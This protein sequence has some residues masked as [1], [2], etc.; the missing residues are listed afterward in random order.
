LSEAASTIGIAEITAIIALVGAGLGAG[1]YAL[2]FIGVYWSVYKRITH[3]DAS[4]ALYATSLIPKTLVA[5]QGIRIFIGW[6]LLSVCLI[7]LIWW[8]QVLSGIYLHSPDWVVRV[9]GAVTYLAVIWAIFKSGIGGAL[10]TSSGRHPLFTGFA[11][12]AIYLVAGLLA[13]P[14]IISGLGWEYG[15]IIPHIV[16][17]WDLIKGLA[18]LAGMSFAAGVVEA[19]QIDPPL[20]TVKIKENGGNTKEGQLVTH[21]DGFWYFFEVAGRLECI[22]DDDVEDA[23][24]S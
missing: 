4:T 16:G 2:G 19:S 24:V 9:G 13:W 1:V 15:R 11:I 14:L 21:A 6:P 8:L 7:L 10:V 17:G 3:D 12:G 22:D 18:V 20:P 5:T 23:W